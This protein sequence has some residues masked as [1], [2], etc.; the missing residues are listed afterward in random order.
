MLSLYHPLLHTNI[1][2]P[3]N[4]GNRRRLLPLGF[5]PQLRSDLRHRHTGIGFP[6]APDSLQRSVRAY[7]LRLRFSG[8]YLHYTCGG[9]I[10]QRSGEKIYHRAIFEAQQ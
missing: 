7:F 3:C 6:L 4:G 8:Y 2:A 9:G 10:C 1:C 5:E